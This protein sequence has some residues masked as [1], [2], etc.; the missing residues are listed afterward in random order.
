[1][2]CGNLFPRVPCLL[3]RTGEINSFTMGTCG[4][5]EKKSSLISSELGLCLDCI[6]C[7]SYIHLLE[8]TQANRDRLPEATVEGW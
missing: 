8:V 2:N 5:C 3:T 7:R 4:I 6:R 1:L